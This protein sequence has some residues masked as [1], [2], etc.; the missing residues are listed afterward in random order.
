MKKIIPL[1][2]KGN[3]L[4]EKVNFV[5]FFKNLNLYITDNH[6]IAFWNWINFIL[7]KDY[8]KYTLIH[9]DEHFDARG[10]C[11]KNVEKVKKELNDLKNLQYFLKS[12]HV[13]STDTFNIA[14]VGWDNYVDL[15]IKLNIFRNIIFFVPN[16]IN[17]LYRE[18]GNDREYPHYCSMKNIHDFNFY[19]SDT[20]NIIL[21]LD[22][23]YFVY[24]VH[25]D[26]PYKVFPDVFINEYFD[27]IIKNIK[28]IS[29]IT[30]ALSP[31]TCGGWENSEKILEL[32][33]EKLG[34]DLKIPLKIY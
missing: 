8:G 27:V 6:R 4:Y 14:M 21:N 15:A 17:D 32:L 31:E 13:N 25:P 34:L 2:I 10:N 5:Y 18:I 30:V 22:L 12:S 9:M 16:Q 19:L 33:I 23:D 28:N 11:S 7:K 24:K 29:L 3:S 1:K 20:E 26:D